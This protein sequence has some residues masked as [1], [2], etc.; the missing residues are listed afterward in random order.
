MNK[1]LSR[2]F[3]AVICIL[4]GLMILVCSCDTAPDVDSDTETES[5]TKT[6]TE[7]PTEK[8]NESE[9]ETEAKT[10]ATP[11]TVSYKITV[12]DEN[13]APL[14]NAVVQLCEGDICLLPTITDANGVAIIEA[15]PA[16]YTAKVTLGG[17]A[18]EEE[19]YSFPDDS[20]EIKIT[21]TK[22]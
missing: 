8:T 22:N 2:K 20:T 19:G 9:S 10:E 11:S 16:D 3:L 13:G 14:S 15:A 1:I 12:V 7:L 17:Y 18:G 6:E 4:L 21:L 5:F